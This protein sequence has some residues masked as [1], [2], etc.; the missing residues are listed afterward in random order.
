MFGIYEKRFIVMLTPKDRYRHNHIRFKGE[1]LNFLVQYETK[2]EGDW[3]SVVRYVQSM[4]LVVRE[5]WD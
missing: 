4:D 2:L 3:F 5:E 1:V